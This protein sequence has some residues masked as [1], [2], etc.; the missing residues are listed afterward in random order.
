MIGISDYHGEVNDLIYADDD[1]RDV[2]R[3]L[4]EKYGFGRDNVYLLVDDAATLENVVQAIDHVKGSADENDEVVLFFSGHGA[5][6]IA[7]DGDRER[8]DEAIVLHDGSNLVYLWDGDLKA[9]FSGF[10]TSRTILV[11]GPCLAGGM[12]DLEAEGRVVIMATTE[13]GFL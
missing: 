13:S 11:F 3:T 12:T 5:R 10:K 8:V 1:A 9:L 4:V 7:E 6:G 2:D